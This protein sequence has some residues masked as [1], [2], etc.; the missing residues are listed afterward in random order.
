MN[1]TVKNAVSVLISVVS[2]CFI[3]LLIIMSFRPISIPLVSEFARNQLDNRFHAYYVDFKDVQTRLRP[4]NGTVEFH[5]RSAVAKDYGE[6]ILAQIPYAIIEI[7]FK[8]IFHDPLDVRKVELIQ[9]KISLIQSVG[10]ALK[11]DIGNSDDGSSGRILETILISIAIAKYNSDSEEESYTKFNIIQ[12][13]LTLA[14]EMSG[15]LLHV[16]NAN[17]NLTPNP[18]GVK[19]QYDLIVSARG[20]NL[21]F[22]GECLYTTATEKLDL[23]I[24]FDNIRPALLTEI[25]PQFNYLTPLEVR[26]TGNVVLELKNLFTINKAEIDLA[27]ENGT[28]EIANYYGKNLEIDA[29]RIKGKS[30]DNFSRIIMDELIIESKA[31]KVNANAIIEKSDGY[32]DIKLNF[33]FKGKYISIFLPRWFAHLGNENL[34]CIDDSSSAYFQSSLT[35]DGIYNLNN[36]QINIVGEIACFDRFLSNN[37]GKNYVDSIL[38]PNAN[39]TQKFGIDGTFEAPNLTI[40]Q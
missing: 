19:C 5:F 22:T 8:S 12:S 7:G 9:P 23:L 6:N 13:D 37:N 15:S 40:I 35:M 16:P 1:V 31:T 36:N 21:H 38:Q 4:F 28:L 17:I 11:F 29:I 27:G 10:G 2:I 33:L 25:S 20:E 24:Q 18:N 34:T 14:D 39:L 26:L 30:M 3:T 32:A